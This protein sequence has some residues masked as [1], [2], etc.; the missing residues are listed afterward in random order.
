ME[1]KSIKRNVMDKN[2]NI[3]KKERIED[4]LL[5]AFVF[6]GLGFGIIYTQIAAGLLIGFGIGMIFR[7]FSKS[8]L[9]RNYNLKVPLGVAAYILIL[10]GLYFIIMGIMLIENYVFFYPFNISYLLIVIG[11]IFL[12]LYLIERRKR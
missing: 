7:E 6:I 1:K 11:I 12:I 10:I 5:L 4:L 9:E 8:K 3:N 2:K